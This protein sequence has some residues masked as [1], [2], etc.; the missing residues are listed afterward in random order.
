MITDANLGW[1]I[2]G[3][4]AV[5]AIAGGLLAVALGAAIYWWPERRKR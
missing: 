3:A 2:A 4:Y 5:G 1:V